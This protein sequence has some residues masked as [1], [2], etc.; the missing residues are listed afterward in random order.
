MWQSGLPVLGICYG[1]QALAHSLGGIVADSNEREFGPARIYRNGAAEH[2]LFRDLPTDLDVWMSH[3]DRI[4]QLPEGWE[5]W[6][7]RTT[8]RIAAMGTA[9]RVGIQFH[10]EVVHTPLG[11]HYPQLPVR[12]LRLR[13][14]LEPGVVHRDD[15]RRHPRARRG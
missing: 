15:H 12:H 8:R 10:P 1:M 14:Q 2:P 9:T 5:R 7:S 13:G 6:P 11:A 4:E 3:G